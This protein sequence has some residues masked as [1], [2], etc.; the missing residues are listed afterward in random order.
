M[1]SHFFQAI[2]KAGTALMLTLLRQVIVL[3]PALIILPRF[4]QLNGVWIAG[5]IADGLAAVITILVLLPEIR[6]LKKET[7][8]INASKDVQENSIVSN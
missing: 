7:A 5:P 1:V 6:T 3:I 4:L 8:V 2:G